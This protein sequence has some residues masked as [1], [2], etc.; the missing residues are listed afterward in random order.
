MTTVPL[1]RSGAS[2]PISTSVQTL[3]DQHKFKSFVEVLGEE[4]W[5]E[6]VAIPF[7]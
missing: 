4:Q 1:T 2:R 3:Q 7:R 6:A 5:E